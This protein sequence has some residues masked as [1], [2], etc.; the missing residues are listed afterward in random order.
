MSSTDQKLVT[1]GVPTMLIRGDVYYWG[2]LMAAALL[3]G[4]PVAI[5]Y[6]FVVHYFIQGLTGTVG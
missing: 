2:S 3:T 1:V 5:V 6:A 4:L